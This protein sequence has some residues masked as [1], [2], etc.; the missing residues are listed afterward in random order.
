MTEAKY[1]AVTEKTSLPE[2]FRSAFPAALAR[3]FGVFL[4]ANQTTL[5]PLQACTACASEKEGK[6]FNPMAPRKK[7]N[8]GLAALGRQAQYSVARVEELAFALELVN[9]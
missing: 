7:A 6:T 9:Y 8:D 4:R 3:A 1:N 5:F 2:A